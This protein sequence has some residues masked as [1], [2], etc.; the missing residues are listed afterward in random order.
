MSVRIREI[1]KRLYLDYTVNGHRHT[2]SLKIKLSDDERNNKELRRLAETI[3]VQKL[4][5]IVSNEHGLIDQIEGRRTLISY[6]EELASKQNA[7]NSLPKSLKYLR[8]FAGSLRLNAITGKWIEEYREYL[9]SQEALGKATAAKYLEALKSLL[10]TATRNLILPKNPSETVQ[11]IRVPETLKPYLTEEELLKLHRTPIGGKL[12]AEVKIAFL[13]GYTTGLRKSDLT[14]LRWGDFVAGERWQIRKVQ[15][16]TSNVVMV[17]VN[18]DAKRLIGIGNNTQHNPT[19]LVF[20]LLSSSKTNTNQYL[21]KWG[22]DAGVD[23]RIGWHISRHTFATL[24]LEHGADPITVQNLLGHKKIATT[25]F[26]AKSTDSSKRKAV[27]N[28]PSIINKEPDDEM[29]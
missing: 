26:Y 2:E 28:L 21:V 10:R 11:S 3:R 5:Q 1:N 7:K 22:K 15:A 23:T 29:E 4:S 9:L 24:A 13:F 6:A 12:G 16:K 8:E 18:E 20:P 25:L 27:D 17:P 14:A 19:D